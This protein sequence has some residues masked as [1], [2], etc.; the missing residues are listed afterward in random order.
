M[1]DFAAQMVPTQNAAFVGLVKVAW[2]LWPMVKKPARR[3]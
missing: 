1:L 2:T 3:T